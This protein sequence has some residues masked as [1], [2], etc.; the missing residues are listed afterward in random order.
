MRHAIQRWV[1]LSDLKLRQWAAE[2]PHAGVTA[3][4]GTPGASPYRFGIVRNAAQY[5]RHFV[6]ACLELEVPFTV[7]DLYRSDW[8]RAV[9][10]SQVDVLLV[11]PDAFLSIWGRMIKDRVEVIERD[12]SIPAV[13]S[14]AELWAYEDKPRMAY[15]LEAH[16]I[17]H[18]RTRVFYDL[19]E[20][21]EFVARCDLPVVSKTAFGASASGVRIHRDRGRLTAYV[22]RAFHRGVVPSGLDRRD[23]QWG[24]VLLQEY[25]PEVIEW[26]M[27][28]IGDSYFG[29][30]KGR[31]GEFH[32]GSGSVHWDV[33]EPRHLDLLHRVTEEGDFRSM[34]VDLFETRDGRLLVNELQAVFGAGF[35]VDQLRVDG[36]PGRFVREPR[37]EWHFESGDFARN[38]CA[39]ERIRWVIESRLAE[40]PLEGSGIVVEPDQDRDGGAT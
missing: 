5:H 36:S 39:N 34:D 23:R 31:V 21:R 9:R 14:S 38:A 12:L 35:S 18:P 40:R 6:A 28:R 2:N 27:V 15:W 11:W 37:G 16:G 24:C 1:S 17:P 26:R 20:C 3:G 4:D 19:A 8:L 30:P 25:L 13:P 29:H 10:E 22:R 33:P 7:V 32:S